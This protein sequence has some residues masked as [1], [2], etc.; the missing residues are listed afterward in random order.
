MIKILSENNTIFWCGNGG[1]A[2]QAN[3]LTAVEA[4]GA[5]FCAF[6]YSS[7]ASNFK[8]GSFLKGVDFVMDPVGGDVSEQAL[9]ATGFNGRH[10]VIGF[11]NGS[12]PKISLN[13]TLVKG[14]S[15]VGVWWGRWT[16]TSPNE[17]AEDF[18]FVRI[19]PINKKKYHIHI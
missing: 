11:A 9:R 7:I 14:V 17:T 4:E 15:I 10:L 6:F 18:Q 16:N 8:G 3:H 1:S 13:L 5:L 19:S 12:I 2:S